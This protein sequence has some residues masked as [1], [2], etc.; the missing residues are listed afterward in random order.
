[1]AITDGDADL[2]LAINGSIGKNKGVTFE[3]EDQY[4]AGDVPKKGG[5]PVQL[6]GSAVFKEGKMIAKLTGEETR[7]ALILDNT[8]RIEDMY[9]SYQD[10]LNHKYKIACR[11]KKKTATKVK[12]KL[13]NG[14]PYY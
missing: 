6:I 7:S 11:L 10:P 12:I 14:P 1:M 8:S 5:N 4:L 3:M 2:F 13:R 9:V